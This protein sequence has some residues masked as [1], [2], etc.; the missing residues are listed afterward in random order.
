MKNRIKTSLSLLAIA[1]FVILNWAT[2]DEYNEIILSADVSIYQDSMIVFMNSDDL[3]INNATLSLLSPLPDGK[4]YNIS[5][6]DLMASASDT[7]EMSEFLFGVTAFTPYPDSLSPVSFE[8][9]FEV[10]EDNGFVSF[11]ENF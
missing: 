1:V 4:Y 9:Y 5:G 8:C 6:Y 11:V 7:I 10:P 3:N 2:S